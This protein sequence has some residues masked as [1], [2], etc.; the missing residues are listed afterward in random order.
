MRFRSRLSFI[1]R[2]FKRKTRHKIRDHDIE[3]ISF[4]SINNDEL[5]LIPRND[6]INLIYDT[7][8]DCHICGE[9]LPF[10][11]FPAE[12]DLPHKCTACVSAI[13]FMPICRP[14]I[15]RVF[16]YSFNNSKLPYSAKCPN[17]E[18]GAEWPY[19]VVQSFLPAESFARY[20]ELLLRSCLSTLDEVHWCP[21]EGC[22]SAQYHV[23][24]C[25]DKNLMKCHACGIESCCE[26]KIPYH[27]GKTCK[28]YND[29]LDQERAEHD[30]RAT[31]HS[32]A[33]LSARRC[34]A[35]RTI[36]EKN[37]GCCFMKCSF[38]RYDFDW[39]CARRVEVP[40]EGVPA[41]L[42]Q[43]LMSPPYNIGRRF[44]RAWRRADKA[45]RAV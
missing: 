34:P 20:D 8:I 23:P 9:S 2:L 40:R 37:G 19:Q 4:P 26:H 29:D 31:L 35:C 11:N 7:H 21:S 33:R 6:E 10:D 1:S 30:T 45:R 27:H 43:P 38:C 3:Q 5:P 13:G 32:L 28:Q 15:A 24:D 18:C 39:N 14:C 36:I 42:V 22:N 25:R 44:R 12:N 16:E 17:P 41:E